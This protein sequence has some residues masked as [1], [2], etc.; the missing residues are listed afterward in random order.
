M[1]YFMKGSL[2]ITIMLGLNALLIGTT[3]SAIISL[4]FAII[5]IPPEITEQ[6]TYERPADFEDLLPNGP[7]PHSPKDPRGYWSREQLEQTAMRWAEYW[8]IDKR[9]WARLI[10]KESSWTYWVHGCMWIKCGW[11]LRLDPARGLTQIRCSTARDM[12]FPEHRRC[13]ELQQD[14]NTTA[15]FSAKFYSKLLK[16]WG[17]DELALAAYFIGGTE[18]RRVLKGKKKYL[19]RS[20]RKYITFIN[21][22]SEV[23]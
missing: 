16:R 2:F 12:G 6:S 14:P 4:P 15:F 10:T 9:I 21:G 5:S 7:P 3:G 8:D 1:K 20:L 18:L 11:S 17:S 13:Y 22:K 23:F 19:R